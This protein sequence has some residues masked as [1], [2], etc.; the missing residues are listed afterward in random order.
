MKLLIVGSALDYSAERFYAK[1]LR[2]SGAD[3]L[4]LDQ[5]EG[6]KNRF[7]LRWAF[8]RLPV[9]GLLG[10]LSVNRKLPEVARSFSPDAIIVFKG[11]LVDRRVLRE[12]SS[13]Y[14]VALFYPD[15][16]RYPSLLDGLEM[17]SVV[18]TAANRVDFYLE[19]GAKKAITIPWAC[20]PSLHR[21]LDV[22]KRYPSSFIGTFYPNRYAAL[23]KVRGLRVF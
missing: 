9:R 23:R 11:E 12:L 10:R 4:L 18:F 7:A 2:E 14:K 6:I 13:S 20:D 15:T 8:T 17:F 1:A 21:K 19:R 22:K 3:V 5:Y 16:Y